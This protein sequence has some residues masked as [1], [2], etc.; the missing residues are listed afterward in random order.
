MI[1]INSIC[2]IHED[3]SAGVIAYRF[4]GEPAFV[5]MYVPDA[6][7]SAENSRNSALRVLAAHMCRKE[8]AAIRCV[9]GCFPQDLW[10]D[11]VCAAVDIGKCIQHLMF[12][13]LNGP[14]FSA[15]AVCGVEELAAQRR[16]NRVKAAYLEEHKYASARLRA[17][18]M[19]CS[20]VALAGAKG[21][22]ERC[23]DAM[24]GA[25]ITDSDDYEF[26]RSTIC[27]TAAMDSFIILACGY[28]AATP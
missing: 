21:D 28:W 18:L 14:S 4:H 24:L 5:R 27:V 12:Q 6:D 16:V 20:V 3:E 17:V 9:L 25:P 15:G 8:A 19:S 10:A 23:V 26:R 11:L 22:A 7:A 1:P 2:T 13:G